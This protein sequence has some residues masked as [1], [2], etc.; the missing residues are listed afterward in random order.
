MFV[1]LLVC[2]LTNSLVKECE[3]GGRGPPA[4]LF[5]CCSIFITRTVYV[6][7]SHQVLSHHRRCQTLGMGRCMT[8][9]RWNSCPA[10]PAQPLL[11]RRCC[12]RCCCC[13][14]PPARNQIWDTRIPVILRPPP[15]FFCLW[16]SCYLP[17]FWNGVALRLLVKDKSP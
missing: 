11:T 4:V 16:R 13:C 2:L 14:C 15:S 8:R 1:F 6:F 9:W 3:G 5:L 10:G 17:E 7:V 12:A